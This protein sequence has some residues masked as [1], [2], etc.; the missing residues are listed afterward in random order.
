MDS[1][2]TSNTTLTTLVPLLNLNCKI[3][4]IR[5]RNL[6]ACLVLFS[7][8]AGALSG[9]VVIASEGPIPSETH[10]AASHQHSNEL[11]HV[12]YYAGLTN[13]STFP[14]E[15]TLLKRVLEEQVT[16]RAVIA[17]TPP[18]RGVYIRVYKTLHH[19]SP[20]ALERVSRLSLY[21]IPYYK[22]GVY[23]TV[24]FDLYVDSVLKKT[25][26][27]GITRKSFTWLLVIPFSWI[28]LL[29]NDHTSA[30]EATIYQFFQDVHGD[31]LL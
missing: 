6:L 5:L 12:F 9:C 24:D 29:T 11:V 25:Y 16:T 10:L 1:A 17:T 28:N 26:R 30:F 19:D 13:E 21:F 8:I 2:A 31:Q 27:Y 20:T 18:E 3:V 23:Y 4:L 14:S 15:I 22:E 7:A